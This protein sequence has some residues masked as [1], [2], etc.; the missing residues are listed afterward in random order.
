[1]KNAMDLYSFPKQTML[2]FPHLIHA[3]SYTRYERCV[4]SHLTID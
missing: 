1:M 4:Q 3:F 2:F